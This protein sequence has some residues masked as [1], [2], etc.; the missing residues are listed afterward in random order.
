[1]NG[2]LYDPAIWSVEN[3]EIVGRAPNGIEHNTWAVGP[4]RFT[5]FRMTV[6]VKLVND[7]GNSG[8]QVRSSRALDGEVSGLQADIGAGWWGKLYEEHGRGLLEAAGAAAHVKRGDWNTYEVV[9]TGDRIQTALN[10]HK[11]VDR[12]DAEIAQQ[13]IVALQL[14]SGG[15]TEVRF[16]NFSFELSPSPQL[17]TTNK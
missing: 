11:I 5:D 3:G 6:E 1:M 16:R 8:I 9:I 10:G 4:L 14:H 7:L 2:W 15:P 12:S 13:G 17:T